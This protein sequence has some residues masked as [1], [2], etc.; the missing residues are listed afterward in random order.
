MLGTISFG[1]C[2][3]LSNHTR[4][5]NKILQ[6]GNYIPFEHLTVL[7]ADSPMGFVG[8]RLEFMP[9]EHLVSLGEVK[10]DCAVLADREEVEVFCRHVRS[11]FLARPSV[12]TTTQ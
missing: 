12:A 5:T 1:Y 3:R 7:V 11:H 4:D 6:F 9:A 10:R 2:F 8:W